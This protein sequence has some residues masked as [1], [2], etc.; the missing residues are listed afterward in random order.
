MEK[1]T[2]TVNDQNYEIE[3]DLKTPLLFVLRNDLGLKAPKL[4]CAKEQCG[5]CKVLVDDVAVPSCEL[6][7]ERVKG[8]KITTLEGLGTAE[9]LHPLQEAFLEEQAAQCGYCSSGMIIAAQGLLNRVRYPTDE[10]IHAAFADNLCR[11]GVYDRVRHAIKLRIGRR[12]FDEL[13]YQ[14][15]EQAPLADH[16]GKL[17]ASLEQFPDIDSWIRINEDKTIT[18]FTGKVELGQGIKTALAQ[19]AAEELDVSPARIQVVTADTQLTPDEGLTAGSMSIEVSGASLRIASAEARHI[20]LTMAFEE[21]ESETPAIELVVEDG[22]ITDPTS[23]RKTTYWDLMAGQRFDQLITGVAKPKHHSQYTLVGH[24]E[25]RLDLLNKLTGGISYV[26]DMDLPGMLHA[27]VLRPPNYYS[28]LVSADIE[29]IKQMTGIVEVLRDGSFLAVI[30]EREEQAIWAVDALRENAVWKQEK[31]LPSQAQLFADLDNEF[32]QSALL[33][34]GTPTDDPIPEINPP[35][36]AEKTLEASY[37]RPYQM[38][39]SLGPSAAV[40][41]WD[42]DQLTI[43]SHTQGAFI[44]Q[45]AIADMLGL[46]LNKIRVIHAEGS[47]AYGHN[48]AEDAAL[49]AVLAARAVTGRPVLL[50]WSRADENAWEPYSS[51][52]F[53]KMNA[54]LDASGKIVDWNHDV[55]SYVHS[56][57]P[58]SG[59]GENAGFVAA[60]HLEKPFGV[61]PARFVKRAEFGGHRNAS[62]GYHFEHQRVVRHFAPNSPLRVSAMRSLGAYANVFAIESFMD[63][64]AIAAKIDP[65]EF[66][67]KHLTDERAI[68]LVKAAAEKSN[69][70]ARIRPNNSGKGRGFAYAQYKNKQCYTAI[71]VDV[72]VNLETGAIQLEKAVIAAD[73]GQIV[74]PD[75]TSNQLE[76]GFMQSAS[77]TLYEQV[78]YDENGITSLDW[79]TYPIM[80]FENAPMLDVV[81]LNRPEQPFLGAGEASQNPTPAAIANAV[82]DAVGLRIR[83]L[84]FTPE[85]VLQA[86]QKR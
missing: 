38:H 63:E 46:A 86:L 39:A 71:V 65:V 82:Y 23:G 31:A 6:P 84:P 58:R 16:P 15:L 70:E 4:G 25:K 52:M 45:G 64:L 3:L 17:P 41:R 12:S 44:L 74:N 75:G 11:C 22:T 2:L 51:A 73:S 18:I 24:P 37:F 35:E 20:M 76:G 68:A 19:I 33:L 40:A 50:K 83:D 28:Q 60:W 13:N 49:D 79:E 43:W 62:P 66:R 5:A 21:L 81:L 29:A 48:G 59:M 54:S 9:E 26:H 72:T 53:M 57:R 8:L 27:R 10:D 78:T 36:N 14:L 7:V 61:P 77:W 69:W 47:G 56:T 32:D 85:K 80:H 67:L 30:A 34:D 42:G 1:I 55:W